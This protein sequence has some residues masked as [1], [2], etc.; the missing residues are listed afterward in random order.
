[1]ELPT[2]LNYQDIYRLGETAVC[3]KNTMYSTTTEGY[4]GIIEQESTNGMVH[5]NSHIIIPFVL[6]PTGQQIERCPVM[7]EATYTRLER[8]KLH[9]LPYH[10][11]VYEITK[12][13]GINYITSIGSHGGRYDN[14]MI[15]F[16]KRGE[17]RHKVMI[18]KRLVISSGDFLTIDYDKQFNAMTNEHQNVQ[19]SRRVRELEQER[20]YSADYLRRHQVHEENVKRLSVP[21]VL[22]RA[23]PT[24]K[25]EIIALRKNARIEKARFRYG[26]FIIMTKAIRRHSEA[27]GKPY[28]RNARLHTLGRFILRI[29]PMDENV[30]S[31]IAC[32]TYN[33]NTAIHPHFSNQ[34]I[35][36]G[37]QRDALIA[38]IKNG[39]IAAAVDQLITALS[40]IPQV[41]GSPYTRYDLFLSSCTYDPV[42]DEQT[43]RREYG[44]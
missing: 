9:N 16:C 13:G 11:M 14:D 29:T 27:T 10:S 26:T 21:I 15:Y 28:S 24:I 33:N 40:F 30:L 3:R 19:E 37:D 7:D 39:Y 4:S 36:T 2:E 20:N 42:R 6:C 12:R 34:S 38:T 22:D 35:C 23:L 25:G 44:H 1:M 5:L 32:G 41:Y 17:E 31:G 8:I 43:A 18:D